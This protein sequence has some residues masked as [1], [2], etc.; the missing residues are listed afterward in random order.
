[1]GSPHYVERLRTGTAG[2]HRKH[3]EQR[4]RRLRRRG[5]PQEWIDDAPADA[6]QGRELMSA[7]F[8]A[9]GADHA[10]LAGRVL[11]CV[12]GR[13]TMSGWRQTTVDRTT[14][15]FTSVA[16]LWCVPAVFRPD[17]SKIGSGI[18]FLMRASPA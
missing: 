2:V 3:T 12:R 10:E 18:R 15:I 5:A 13:T 6:A 7:V 14:L 16:G 8:H 11:T 17:P 1:M 4:A 9:V